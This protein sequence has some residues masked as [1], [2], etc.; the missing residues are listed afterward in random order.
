[1]MPV[2]V[3]APTLTITTRMKALTVLTLTPMR[4]AIY[5][6]VKPCINRLTVSCPRGV[7]WCASHTA[8]SAR[9]SG[10]ALSIKRMV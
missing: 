5:L 10:T 7:R 4:V 6:F 2:R 8:E 3:E 1:M 9:D